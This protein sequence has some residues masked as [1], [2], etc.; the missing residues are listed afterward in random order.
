[1]AF[2]LQEQ[3]QIA[4]L[5]G[6]WADWGK[7]LTT[8]AAVALIAYGGWTG[9]N[10]WRDSQAAAAADLYGQLETQLGGDAAKVRDSA[11]KIKA[12]YGDSAY[13][14]RAALLAAK[15]SVRANDFKSAQTQLEWVVAHA[16]EAEVRDAGRLRLSAVLLDQKA[17]DEAVKALGGR[18]VDANAGLFA[19]SRGDVLAAKGDNNA[20]RDAYKEA[21]AKLA[22]DAPN[23]K[24]V[25]VKL[26]A[27]GN[28]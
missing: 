20:A 12:Q 19:E 27:L 17:Y 11:D 2:D 23:A 24:F 4:Q 1:M 28:A 15:A 5:K 3:E 16:K 26:E 21:L 10:S 18:E 22:K 7:Y 25:Q 8:A 14:P 13:A 6:W 9:Y